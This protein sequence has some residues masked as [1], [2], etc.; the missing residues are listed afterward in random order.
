MLPMPV[1]APA[2]RQATDRPR[3]TRDILRATTAAS[4]SRYIMPPP[5]RS[6]GSH[7]L[8]VPPASRYAMPPPECSVVSHAL[9]VPPAG[10]LAMPPPAR[11]V[12][13]LALPVP[14]LESLFR[15]PR[16]R[17]T[18]GYWLRPEMPLL[19]SGASGFAR[20]ASGHREKAL[21]TERPESSGRSMFFA[22]M[23]SPALLQLR[24]KSHRYALASVPPF[25]RSRQLAG[26]FRLIRPPRSLNLLSQSGPIVRGSGQS[27]PEGPKALEEDWERAGSGAALVLTNQWLL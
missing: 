21:N 25:P 5:A 3:P 8:P 24:L 18:P 1:F 4:S 14:N 16:M 27:L 12:G 19:G 7:A 26:G 13:S 22:P 6:V 15:A 9:P 10:R 2:V 20:C 11:S 23:K 17:A